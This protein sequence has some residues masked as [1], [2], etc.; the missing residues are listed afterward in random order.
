MYND[1]GQT[2]GLLVSE[3]CYD[4][5]R[6]EAV[7]GDALFVE[8]TSDGESSVKPTWDVELQLGAGVVLRLRRP[9]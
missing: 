8:L 5:P 4:V 7:V 3:L 9:C 2:R 6:G 1:V